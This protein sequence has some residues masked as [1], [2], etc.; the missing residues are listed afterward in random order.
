M[1]TRHRREFLGIALTALVAPAACV[2]AAPAVRFAG[3]APE[4]IQ[5]GDEQAGLQAGLRIAHLR[6]AYEVGD[7]VELMAYVRNRSSNPMRFTYSTAFQ[8]QP[9][10]V[11]GPD[12][13]A[14]R[15][16]GSTDPAPTKVVNLV[17]LPAGET[18]V[19]EHP[20][21]W[22]PELPGGRFPAI[23]KPTPGVY[24]VWQTLRCVT[25]PQAATSVRSH[26]VTLISASGRSYRAEA[27]IVP[28]ARG[29]TERSLTTGAIEITVVGG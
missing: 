26:P 22:L 4:A 9:P 18:L 8:E 20:G 29:E 1:R 2:M 24:R 3:S 5:W 16:L 14:L 15:V 19:V 21:L 23:L 13:R 17:T 11:A 27:S 7:H 28:L 25:N 12:G 6:P 10:A